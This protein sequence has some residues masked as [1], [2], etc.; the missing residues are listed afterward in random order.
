MTLLLF[1]HHN[2]FRYTQKSR[3]PS[4]ACILRYDMKLHKLS[5]V[6][7]VAVLPIAY[8]SAITPTIGVASAV[9]TFIVNSA[10]V[11]GNAN[12]FDGSQ[13]RTGKASSKVYLM[14]GAALVLGVDSAGTIYRNHFLLQQGATKVDNLTDYAI[15]ADKYQIRQNQPASQAVVRMDK[16]GVEVAALTGS[17]DVFNEKGVLLTRIGAGTASAFQSGA[18]TGQS[19]ASTANNNN[20]RRKMAALY[21][22]T[23]VSMAGL[24]LAADAILQPASTS[25]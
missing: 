17:L 13:I 1:D 5:S 15:Q 21:A 14:S 11:E 25:P 24:G 19:G 20:E 16:D 4:T 18:S 8:V 7:L 10:E 9:G 2:R 6:L 22:A 3:G 12:L 23:G